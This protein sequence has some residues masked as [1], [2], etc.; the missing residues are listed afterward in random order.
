MEY[1]P[2]NTWVR[3][4]IFIE[5]EGDLLLTSHSQGGEIHV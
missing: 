3:G 5:R 4:L 2:Y 1:A